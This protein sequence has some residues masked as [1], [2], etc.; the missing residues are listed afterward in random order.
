[1]DLGEGPSAHQAALSVGCSLAAAPGSDTRNNLHERENS[2]PS[3]RQLLQVTVRLPEQKS[4]FP[5]L[6]RAYCC[7]AQANDSAEQRPDV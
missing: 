2:L 6:C 7:A 1:M 4:T 5:D 3:L